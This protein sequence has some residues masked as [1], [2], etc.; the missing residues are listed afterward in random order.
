MKTKIPRGSWIVTVPVAV[1]AVVY[2]VFFFLPGK[3]AIGELRDRIQEY[4][5]TIDRAAVVATALPA[6]QKEIKKAED[7]NAAWQK[8]APA[9]SEIATLHGKINALALAV[10][11]ELT[12]LD[13]EPVVVYG[14]IRRIP[15]TVGCSGSF[16]QVCGFLRSLEG[17]PEALWID[18]L[19]LE[20][21]DQDEQSVKC[22]LTLVV[23]A[24]NP[25]N[26]D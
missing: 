25:E 17:L 19:N 11:T 13:P 2:V 14:K 20:N 8:D 22:E 24:D 5:E 15:L 23:F 1:V 21:L 6:V 10:G 7:Y 26:S 9:A 18:S 3:R 4:Q 12:R 16:A